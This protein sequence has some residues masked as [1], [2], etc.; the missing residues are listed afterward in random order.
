MPS[1]FLSVLGSLATGHSTVPLAVV[2][3][4]DLSF[5]HLCS[6]GQASIPGRILSDP[7]I[8]RALAREEKVAR[9]RGSR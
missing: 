2:I 4:L 6:H 9:L 8:D 5:Q 1:P 3:H 7:V